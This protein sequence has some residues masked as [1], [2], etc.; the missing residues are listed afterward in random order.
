MDIPTDLL[1]TFL[2]AADAK[3][4][5]AAAS[6]VHRT[7]SAVSMQMRRLEEMIR[8][9]LFKR[10]GR[11]MELTSEG[12]TLLWYARRIL[13]LHDEA[14]AAVIRPELSGRVCVGAPEDY[15]ERLLPKVL[16]RFAATYPQVQVDLSCLFTHQ[17]IKALDD[18]ELDLAV[19]NTGE[20]AQRGQMIYREQVVWI[21][22]DQHL[23]HEQDPVP[24]ALYYEDCVYREWAVKSLQG[25]NRNYRIAYTSP[26]IAGILA[27]VKGGLAVAPIARSS[28]PA[29]VRILGPADGFPLLPSA[30]ITLC[31]ARK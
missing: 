13:K 10:N 28:I 20:V 3:S 2:T 9:P 12:Q 29:G 1:R 19:L 14:L 11:S 26:G 15:A 30:I 5:T 22:S 21:T 24:L 23:V 27:A 31:K 18:G 4:Y 7:Q 6:I 25:I 8:R 17:L 16:A